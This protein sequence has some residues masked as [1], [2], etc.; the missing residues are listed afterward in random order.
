MHKQCRGKVVLSVLLSIIMVFSVVTVGTVSMSAETSTGIGLCAY[1]LNAYNEGWPYV[2]GGC[3]YGAVDCSGLIKSYNGVGGVRTDMLSSSQSAGLDWGYVSNGVPNIHG[4]GLHKPGHVGVYVGSDNAIDARGTNWGIIYASLSSVSWVEWYKLVGVSYPESG[5]VRFDGESFYYENGE[6]IESTTR[7]IDGVNYSFDSLGRSDKEPP[8]SA[9]EVTDYSSGSSSEITTNSS[10]FLKVGS[11]GEKVKEVQQLLKDLGYFDDEVTGYYGTYTAACV[12][13]FQTDANIE[14]DGIV[15]PEFMHTIKSENAPSKNGANT[16]NESDAIIAPTEEPTEAITEVSTEVVT[17]A[18]TE[19][20][21]EA[22]TEVST[23]EITEISTEEVTEESTEKST[24]E[25]TEESTEKSTEAVT[26]AP[27]EAPTLPPTP[28]ED[29]IM[30]YGENDVE[31]CSEIADMQTRLTELGYYTAEVTGVFD[32]NTLLALHDYFTTSELKAVDYITKE[33]YDILLSDSAVAKEV[34]GQYS[35]EEIDSVQALLVKLS[36]L[37]E[38]TGVYDEATVN[39]VKT[40]QANFDMEVTGELSDEFVKALELAS[41][42]IDS[43]A[44]TVTTPSAAASAS[45]STAVTATA[46]NASTVTSTSTTSQVASKNAP[47]TGYTFNE[48]SA[49]ATD[50]NTTFVWIAGMMI[51][52]SLGTTIVYLKSKISKKKEN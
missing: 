49:S 18:P 45:A 2:W 42:R 14:V 41:A 46:N 51:A 33:Q 36:Y 22:I 44:K 27:T 38:V 35:Q 39:A 11:Q 5:W 17:E 19:E 30:T 40:A 32:N 37:D 48:V 29:G 6:Y 21:T 7:T 25:V 52:L 4:L 8:E 26:E 12:K 28:L 24:E 3:S 13:E 43:Q 23:E 31:S 16:S 20:P 9:Y 50:D 15:G 1:A 47:V 10:T 34:E